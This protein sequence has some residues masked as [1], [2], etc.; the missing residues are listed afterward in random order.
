MYDGRGFAL[1]GQPEA[2]RPRSSPSTTSCT[3]SPTTAPTSRASSRCS[4]SSAGPTPTRRAS[5]GWRRWSACS[6]PGTS[7]EHGLLPD[8]RPRAQAAAPGMR[9]RLADAVR[10][11]KAV[12]EDFGTDLFGVDFHALGRPPGRRGA[13]R[14]ST[15]TEVAGGDRRRAPWDSSIRPACRN[16][17][18]RRSRNEPPGDESRVPARTRGRGRRRAG[19]LSR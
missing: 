19:R 4:R 16:V 11:G 7:H 3:C 8:R 9:H 14:C 10:R 18:G 12:A 5:R 1:P 17:S 15:P 13:R 2:A 6:R